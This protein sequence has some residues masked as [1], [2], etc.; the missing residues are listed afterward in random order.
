MHLGF[1]VATALEARHERKVIEVIEQQMPRMTCAITGA[2]KDKG[3][4]F[5]A[6]WI[7]SHTSIPVFVLALPSS[8][9]VEPEVYTL[10]NVV[11]MELP[12]RILKK[13]N[14]INNVLIRPRTVGVNNIGLL[15]DQYCKRFVELCDEITIFVSRIGI[16]AYGD[17]V[18]AAKR[19]GKLAN[20]IS[21]ERDIT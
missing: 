9:L 8:S 20:V 15:N 6:R 14:P 5:V 4:V 16:P 11:V 18:N 12:R 19:V 21:L 1:V 2:Y 3:D 10:P 13:R 17:I 7:S